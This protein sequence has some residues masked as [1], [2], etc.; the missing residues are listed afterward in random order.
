MTLTVVVVPSL[1]GSSYREFVSMQDNRYELC[2]T[3]SR[4]DLNV[5]SWS[6]LLR[7]P[8]NAAP[9]LRTNESQPIQHRSRSYDEITV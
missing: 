4:Y 5:S 7:S 3:V 9:F 6:D 2:A 1:P 8:Y